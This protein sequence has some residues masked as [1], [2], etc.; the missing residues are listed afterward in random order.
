MLAASGERSNV[1][2]KNLQA[3]PFRAI[4]TVTSNGLGEHAAS[5]VANPDPAETAQHE[6]ARQESGRTPVAALTSELEAA[7]AIQ[8]QA[9]ISSI[10]APIPVDIAAAGHQPQDSGE[11]SHGQWQRHRQDQ[12]S[13]DRHETKTRPQHEQPQRGVSREAS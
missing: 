10:G 12:G 9:A 7:F 4:A 11:D 13:A 3:A 1:P 8:P 6:A 2:P 5:L